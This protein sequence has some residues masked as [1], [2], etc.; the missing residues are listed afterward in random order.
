MKAYYHLFY[1]CGLQNQHCRIAFSRIKV[2]KPYDNKD[3]IKMKYNLLVWIKKCSIR[4]LKTALNFFGWFIISFSEKFG[5]ITFNFSVSFVTPTLHVYTIWTC[6]KL[7]WSWVNLNIFPTC[8]WPSAWYQL[9][10]I[11]KSSRLIYIWQ[12]IPLIPWYL[13]FS[14]FDQWGSLSI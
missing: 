9:Q 14:R 1:F 12:I 11:S 10:I 4:C 7:G 13:P 3:E 2:L 8:V 5:V 6:K